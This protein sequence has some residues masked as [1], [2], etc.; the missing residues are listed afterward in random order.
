MND[1]EGTAQRESALPALPNHGSK[2][3]CMSE[4]P[5]CC[6]LWSKQALISTSGLIA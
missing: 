2:P 3:G 1:H 5:E 6:E 4:I